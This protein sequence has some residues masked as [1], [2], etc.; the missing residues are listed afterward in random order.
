MMEKQGIIECVYCGDAD[1]TEENNKYGKVLKCQ[2]CGMEQ[3][4]P[5]A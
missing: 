4:I 3:D 1:L 5:D 2:N